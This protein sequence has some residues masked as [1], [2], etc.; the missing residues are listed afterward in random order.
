MITEQQRRAAQ[1]I[2]SIFET[3]KAQGDPG[4]VAVLPDGAGI[5]YGIHQATDGADSL[6]AILIRALELGV[7][8]AAEL[9]ELLRHLQADESARYSSLKGAPA[10]LVEGAALLRALGSDPVMQRAQQEVFEAL[11]WAPAARQCVEMGL[12]L[13]LSWAIVY[14][15]CIH[16]GPAGVGRIRA[17]FAELPPSRGGDERAW[18]IAYVRARRSWLLSR[19]GI[20]ASTTYRMDAFSALMVAEN[21]TLATPFSVRGVTVR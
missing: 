2:V 13:P 11:Y 16:S 15:T 10:W 6:D 18:A 1:A 20:V 9:R 3:G 4:A 19:G 21:W 12:I 17:R 8:R 14:D 5:S 7:G